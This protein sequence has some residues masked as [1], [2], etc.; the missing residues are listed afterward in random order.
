MRRA[1]GE[2]YIGGIQ[3]NIS[4]FRTI[5]N[6]SAFRAGQ[7]DT[8]YLDR[9]LQRDIEPDAPPSDL[10]A[11]AARVA[12]ARNRRPGGSSEGGPATASRWVTQGREDFLR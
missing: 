4:L 11:V 8:G 6:D 9:L 5:L 10:A 12:L 7:L 2:Y 3:S 1:L